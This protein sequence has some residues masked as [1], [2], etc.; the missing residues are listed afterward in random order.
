MRIRHLLTAKNDDG[1]S[2]HLPNHNFPQSTKPKQIGRA[3]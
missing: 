1:S 2:L 3:A